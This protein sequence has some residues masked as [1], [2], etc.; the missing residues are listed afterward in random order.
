MRAGF[1][2]NR[3]FLI[4][5]S[6]GLATF[7]VLGLHFDQISILGSTASV[8]HPERIAFLAWIVWAWALA[9]YIVWFR[10][11]G[12]LS[13]FRA[14]VCDDCALYIGKRA[15]TDRLPDWLAN[16]LRDELAQKLQTARDVLKI[17]YV[18][19]F[20]DVTGDARVLG[21]TAN[22][23]VTALARTANN[24]TEST[25]ALRYERPISASEWRW[26][27][28]RAW[29]QVLVTR[30]FTLEYFAPFPIALLPLVMALLRAAPPGTD[31]T[32]V[33]V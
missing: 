33:V 22:I 5:V 4:A 24:Y 1:V 13:E 30:R 25:G 32:L 28:A 7:N 18:P 14:A 3:R 19:K 11:L 23:L 9:Q 21:R 10:D 26:A 8:Q 6:V 20:V 27:M 16:Q 15:E 29:V 2:R 17:A 12:A 31:S